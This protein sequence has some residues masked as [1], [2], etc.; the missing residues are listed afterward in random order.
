MAM[1]MPPSELL[2]LSWRNSQMVKFSFSRRKGTGYFLGF[3][4]LC[5]LFGLAQKSANDPW[6]TLPFPTSF[7]SQ[8]S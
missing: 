5:G 7:L 3:G 8:P 4:G 6:D 2:K 1:A